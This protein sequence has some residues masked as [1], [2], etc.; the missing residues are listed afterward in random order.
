MNLDIWNGQSV[1]C[2]QVLSRAMSV[3]DHDRAHRATESQLER[4]ERAWGQAGSR[5]YF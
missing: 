4:A 1:A 3:K 2:E 5:A